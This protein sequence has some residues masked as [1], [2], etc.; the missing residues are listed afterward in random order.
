MSENI[1]KE[2]ILRLQIE[3]LVEITLKF[4][5]ANLVSLLIPA[6][7]LGVLLNSIICEMDIQISALFEAEL[8]GRS[9][10]VSFGE[11]IGFDNAIEGSEEHVM[12]DIKLSTFVKKWLLYILLNDK[13][14]EA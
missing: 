5:I 7:F 1:A 8:R 6:V 10:Y 2:I 4:L 9:S 3:I 12:T 11:P 14:S 13:G